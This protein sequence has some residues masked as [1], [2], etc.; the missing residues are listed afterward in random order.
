MNKQVVQR[1][2]KALQYKF[3][4]HNLLKKAL[5]HSS[6]ADGKLDSNERL[7]FLGDSVLGLVICQGL[8]ERFPGYLEGDLTKIKSQLVS[9]KTCSLLA[10][11]LGIDDTLKIGPGMQQSKSLKGSIAAAMLESL[12]A[13]IYIDGGFEQARAFIMRLFGPLIDQADANE[14]QENYKSLLQQYAQ[15]N[16]SHSVGYV[17][18][19]EKGPDHN[20]CFESAAV[21][22]HKRYPSAW[23]MTKKESQQKAAYNALVE[24]EVIKGKADEA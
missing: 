20:K 4:D 11:Q 12:I 16:M 3:T 19:D 15:Q 10:D 14:H 18:L 22:D 2:E 17:V 23:G 5:T 1:V 24:L 21:I 6:A 7:E 8:F 9:R 13:A